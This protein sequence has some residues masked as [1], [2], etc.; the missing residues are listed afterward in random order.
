MTPGTV[1]QSLTGSDSFFE[2]TDRTF[3]YRSCTNCR[4]LFIDPV[5][6]ER[7]LAKF[8]PSN[9]WWNSSPALLTRLECLYR[10]VALRDHVT[11]IGRAA[12]MLPRYRRPI[13][14]LDVG[15]GSGALLGLLVQ[16]GF[17]VVGFDMSKEAAAIAKADHGVHVIT[18]GRLQDGKFLSGA[19]DVVSLFHVVE[20]VSEPRDLLAEVRRLLHSRGRVVLQV[21]NIESWQFKVCGGRWHGLDA[22]RHVINYSNRAIRRLLSDSGFRVCRTRHF[23]LRDNAPALASSLFPSLDPIR[24][25]VRQ[26][27]TNRPESLLLR[28][29]RHAIYLGAVVAAYP[30][31][32]AESVAGSGATVMIEAEKV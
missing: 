3:G 22:P 17:E 6:H 7:E 9:Y 4:C 31:A 20:H 32:I 8:Y 24:R 25:R 26:R 12:A 13:R 23:N 30:F 21:P 16:K 28:W 11:F 5:P 29:A 19:F 27:R 10:R 1:P 15:C 2:T 14:L 18:G